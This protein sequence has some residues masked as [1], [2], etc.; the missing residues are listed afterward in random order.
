MSFADSQFLLFLI[1]I[2]AVFTFKKHF[3]TA[4]LTVISF[5]FYATSGFLLPIIAVILALFDLHLSRLIARSDELRSKKL[6]YLGVFIN[7]SLLLIVK[8]ELLH[9]MFNYGSGSV[10]STVVPIGISFYV[11]QAIGYLIDVQKGKIKPPESTFDFLAYILFFPQLLA[12]PIERAQQLIPQ[13]QANHLPD[14]NTLAFGVRLFFIGLYLKLIV[15]NRLASHVFEIANSQIFDLLFWING[16]VGTFFVYS[17]FFAY[18]LMARGIALFFGIKLQI[19]FDRPFSKKNP[20]SFW[21]AW[22]ISLTKWVT[23]YFYVPFAKKYA[24]TETSKFFFT[25]AAMCII[26]LWH[27]LA[28]SFLVFGVINGVMI[29]MSPK[30]AK[31]FGQYKTN[32]HIERIVLF[33]TMTLAGNVFLLGNSANLLQM[34]DINNYSI[35]DWQRFSSLPWGSILYAVI[36]AVPLLIY[37]FTNKLKPELNL[38]T[39]NPSIARSLSIAFVAFIVILLFHSTESS[40]HVYYKF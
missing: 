14:A 11:L 25:I 23:N 35:I 31:W 6:L 2:L 38:P 13:L 9:L 36:G 22:H 40:T 27:G 33:G 20:S 18:T 8:A 5:V 39:K 10:F 21:Q 19:N 37:E 4:W 26:G 29:R 34:F 17:D 7:L 28:V 16:I 15:S 1:P 12:G 24:G 32:L 3:T 30:I